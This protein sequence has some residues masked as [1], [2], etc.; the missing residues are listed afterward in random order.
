[1][2]DGVLTQTPLLDGYY[3]SEHLKALNV[4]VGQFKVPYTNEQILSSG[5]LDMVDRSIT[6]DEFSMERD[7]GLDLR[8]DD[9]LEDER[10]SYDLGVFMGEG[11]GNASSGDFGMVYVGRVVVRPM[12]GFETP[13]RTSRSAAR[14][15]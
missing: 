13:P 10:L 9:L 6:H 4:R 3:T 5:N 7:I 8:S 12:G 2:A 1:M 14:S 11:Q 15:R